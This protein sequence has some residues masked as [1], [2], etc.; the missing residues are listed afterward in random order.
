MKCL[1]NL[2][3]NKKCIHICLI[4]IA[5]INLYTDHQNKSLLNYYSNP[6][7]ENITCR[8]DFSKDNNTCQPRCDRFEQG[9]HIRTQI[10]IYSEVVAS[11]VALLLCIL[12]VILS[13]KNYKT[14]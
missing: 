6:T 10:L 8:S 4:T 5:S 9:P 11:C 7:L 2:I 12:I 13:I 1:V 3:K 14:M